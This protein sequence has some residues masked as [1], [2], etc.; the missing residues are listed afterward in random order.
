MDLFLSRPWCSSLSCFSAYGRRTLMTSLTP[1]LRV[2]PVAHRVAS[3]TQRPDS[4]I[5]H[6]SIR[7]FAALRPRRSRYPP[8][9]MGW[10]SNHCLRTLYSHCSNHLA[11][12]A[13]SAVSLSLNLPAPCLRPPGLHCS[14]SR[15]GH[16]YLDSF[17]RSHAT[18][19]RPPRT[20]YVTSAI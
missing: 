13:H 8:S 5:G 3:H 17:A 6:R 10:V 19:R 4:P 15:P 20:L 18:L 9:A 2:L 16:A 1:H 7:Q 14:W 12:N 11:Q